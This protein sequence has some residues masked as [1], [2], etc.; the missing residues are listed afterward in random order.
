MYRKDQIRVTVAIALMLLIGVTYFFSNSEEI[1]GYAAIGGIAIWLFLM[2]YL[3][4]D[5]DFLD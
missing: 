3:R 4:R 1:T 2:Y 5:E